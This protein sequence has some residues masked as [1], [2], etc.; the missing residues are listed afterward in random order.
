MNNRLRM[1]TLAILAGLGFATLGSAALTYDA[2]IMI[3]RAVNSP[4][5]TIRYN[6]AA[7][8][9]IELK[10]NGV[11]LGT[12]AVSPTKAAGEVN[13]MID[14]SAL[15]DGDNELEV[16]LFDRDGRLV[17]TQKSNLSTDDGMPSPVKITNPKIGSTVQGPVEIRIGFGREIRGAYVSFFVD[18]QFRAMT[19][20]APYSFVWDT[21]RETNGWHE[22]EAWVVDETSSTFKTRKTRIFVNNPGGRTDRRTTVPVGT[23]PVSPTP[24]TG[25]AKIELSPSTNPLR[26]IP[27]GVEAPLRASI[28]TATSAVLNP[29][30]S[31]PAMIASTI[32][33]PIRAAVGAMST[34][35]SVMLPAATAAGPK[36]MTPTGTR[37]IAPVATT[38][39]TTKTGT[40][41]IKT[42]TV[43]PN[44]TTPAANAVKAAKT[45]AVGKGTRL[46]NTTTFS[47]MMNNAPVKFD[48]SPK[49]VE[50]I[51][52]TPFRHLIEHNGGK[53]DWENAAKTVTAMT[54]GKDIYLKI[55]DKMARVNKLPV[56][57]E[58]APFLEKGR[59]MVP[60]SFL[61]DALGVEIEFDPETGH[62]LITTAKKP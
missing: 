5:L 30:T 8:A 15:H 44:V 52:L 56:P 27:N 35:R 46:P 14:L 9:T 43:K 17:G 2:T 59:T 49:T 24:V 62:V 58:I 42:T 39:A 7:A 32:S 12:R 13:F 28:P 26:V 11:S 37:T 61:K 1:K 4:T 55:G 23:V 36:L 47:V 6:G 3:D 48:V 10:L 57:L 29:T 40:I 54:D 31:V 51:P 53:V 22:V 19:N 25:T 21:I 34:T 60:L 18:N 38:A 16:R 20:Y 45:I 50:G 33:N 41:N